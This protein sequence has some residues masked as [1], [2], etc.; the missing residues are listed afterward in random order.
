MS[1]PY[2]VNYN[3][4]QFSVVRED[5][6]IERKIIHASGAKKI[7]LIGSG[8]CT[9]LSLQAFF[10]QL[11]I[12]LVDP[13]LAQIKLIQEKMR[14]LKDLFIDR[15]KTFNI[16]NDSSI[17]LNQNGNFESLFR[18]F[19][20]FIY[21]FVLSREELKKLLTSY[22]SARSNSKCNILCEIMLHDKKIQT[23]NS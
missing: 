6:E 20:H 1:L 8:G 7:L 14:A 9:A 22:A 17:S 23:Y 13:N 11:R 5:P 21:E 12:T 18:S 16:E 2:M 10:P 19:R 4:I 3:P 15:K